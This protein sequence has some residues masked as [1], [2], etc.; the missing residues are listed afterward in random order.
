MTNHF[1]NPFYDEMTPSERA[2]YDAAMEYQ[3]ALVRRDMERPSPF[4]AL[5]PTKIKGPKYL[6]PEPKK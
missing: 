5:I 4:E 1:K 3:L 6:M 2:R